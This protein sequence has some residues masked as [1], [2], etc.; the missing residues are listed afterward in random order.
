MGRI[1][2]LILLGFLMAACA[3]PA[4]RTA[5]PAQG[6]PVV[7]EGAVSPPTMLNGK[8]V[9]VLYAGSLVNLMES[10]IGPAFQK[11][12]GGSYKGQGAG[13]VALANAI[14]DGTKRGDVFIS[15]DTAVNSTLMG[16]ANGDS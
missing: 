13:S 8:P 10:D 12:T 14:R 16:P 11:S 1:R 7:S 4:P 9:S 3:A 2:M 5:G 15:A 6:S